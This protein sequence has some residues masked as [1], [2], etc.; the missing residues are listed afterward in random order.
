MTQ[1]DIQQLQFAQKQF[2]SLHQQTQT[3]QRQLIDIESAL[4]ELELASWAYEMVGTVMIKKSKEDL[5]KKLLEKQSI[6]KQRKTVFEKQES[7]LKKQIESMQEK[8]L[9]ALD[10]QESQKDS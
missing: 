1:Q 6:I 5:V 10:E 2:S 7:E 8:L 4:N 9:S 3:L